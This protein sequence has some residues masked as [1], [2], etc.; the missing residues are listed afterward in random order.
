MQGQDFPL[1]AWARVGDRVSE[2]GAGG[3][4]NK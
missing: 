3:L 4:I 2:L 1:E